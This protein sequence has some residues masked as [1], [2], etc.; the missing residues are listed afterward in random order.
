VSGDEPVTGAQASYLKTLSEH[1][2]QQRSMTL[3]NPTGELVKI[4]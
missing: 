3:V 1:A 4:Y 2:N